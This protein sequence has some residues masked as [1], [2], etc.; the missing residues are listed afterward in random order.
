MVSP[1]MTIELKEILL[2]EFGKDVTLAAADRLGN[3][4][5]NYI[6]LLSEMDKK[7]LLNKD[8]NDG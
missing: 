5:V 8:K 6:L 3:S 7:I 4:L 2:Q 1:E